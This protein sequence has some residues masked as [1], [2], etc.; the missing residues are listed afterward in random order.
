[1][2]DEQPCRQDEPGLA[3]VRLADR[4]EEAGVQALDIGQ[5]R[6]VRVGRERA[7]PARVLDDC[8]AGIVFAKLETRL[9]LICWISVPSARV[10]WCV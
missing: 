1:M 8:L 2:D 4:T 5:E 10:V 6:T 7:R 9:P 3:G